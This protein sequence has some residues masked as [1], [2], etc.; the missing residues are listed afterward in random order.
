MDDDQRQF[1]L[2][3]FVEEMGLFYEQLGMPRMAG[4]VLGWLLISDPP[5]QSINDLVDALLVSKASIS[6]TTRLLIQLG[7]I[8]RMSLRG[9]RRDYFR[10]KPNA[11]QQL[12]KEELLKLSA[13]RKLADRGLELLKD[14]PPEF[15]ARLRE[16]RDLYAFFERELPPILERWEQPG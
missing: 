3:H 5:H 4:R 2:K 15:R 7:L 6:N 9:H 10:I 11:W 16:M 14:E 8:E 1:E 13:I 12:V